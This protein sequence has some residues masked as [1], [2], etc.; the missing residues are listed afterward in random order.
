LKS[1]FYEAIFENLSHFEDFRNAGRAVS[2][3]RPA[4]KICDRFSPSGGEEK[5]ANSRP[6]F[7]KKSKKSRYF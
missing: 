2:V 4:I 7:A 6:S 1:I 5:G 3:K